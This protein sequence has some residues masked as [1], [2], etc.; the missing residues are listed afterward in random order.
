MSEFYHH[1]I[2]GMRWGIR[3]YQNPDGTLTPAG[4]ERYASTT[5]SEGQDKTENTAKETHSEQDATSNKQKYRIDRAK[6]AFRA[7]MG[8]AAAFAIWNVKQDMVA[9]VQKGIASGKQ[10]VDD[11][12]NTYGS[13]KVKEIYDYSKQYSGITDRII[14]FWMSSSHRK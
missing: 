12:V 10:A 4:R 1:G 8:T 6:R 11:L 14:R 7:A 13:D 2:L 9:E 5:R 3:R